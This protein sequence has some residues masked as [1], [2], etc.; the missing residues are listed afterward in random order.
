MKKNIIV[1][2]VGV[3]FTIL[4]LLGMFSY[5]G[6]KFNV[7]LIIT[8][9]DTY[10]VKIGQTKYTMTGVTEISLTSGTHEIEIT[11][12]NYL[13]YKSTINVGRNN[14]NT[15][16]VDMS[17]NRKFPASISDIKGI[18]TNLS[19]R[20]KV[21][22]Q[23]TFQNDTWVL[24]IIQNKIDPNDKLLLMA[25]KQNNIWV[26][27]LGPGAVF[28]QDQVNKLPQDARND[29]LFFSESNYGEPDESEHND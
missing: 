3:I 1:I 22:L 5:F 27:A 19:S 29:V 8:P 18:N 10:D 15:I 12:K 17:G 11:G 25:N 4:T 9:T 6:Q 20:Y 28:T 13:P 16:K 24:M 14:S 7:Q 21:I 26:L 23:K 2:I